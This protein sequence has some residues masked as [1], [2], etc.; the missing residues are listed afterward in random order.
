MVGRHDKDNL[1][2]RI[3]VLDWGIHSEGSA[4][5]LQRHF[6]DALASLA[7]KLSVTYFNLFS[8]YSLYS[9][10]SLTSLYSVRDWVSTFST[11]STVFGSTF[12]HFLF[13]SSLSCSFLLIFLYRWNSPD[14]APAELENGKVNKANILVHQKSWESPGLPRHYWHFERMRNWQSRPTSSSRPTS[15]HTWWTGSPS[16]YIVV[17]LRCLVNVPELKCLMINPTTKNQ[18]LTYFSFLW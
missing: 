14:P 6:L 5:Q 13:T 18:N 7:F 17:E 16:H 15:R 1:N 3:F 10:H 4:Q 2:W 12:E 8:L 11:V 9:Q